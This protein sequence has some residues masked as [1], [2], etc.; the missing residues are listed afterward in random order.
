MNDPQVAD[1]ERVLVLAPQ[2]IDEALDQAL[3]ALAGAECLVCS[4]A[5]ELAR[6]VDENTGALVITDEALAGGVRPLLEALQRQPS[7][8]DVP[9]LILL[10]RAA[11]ASSARVIDLL[12]NVMILERPVRAATLV[13]AL[14]S[15]IR[16]RRRQYDLR[17]RMEALRQSEER[18]RFLA[19]N[20]PAFV[21]VAAPDGSLT[22]A[23]GKWY[24]YAGISR[25]DT[26]QWPLIVLHPED[27]DIFLQRW[28]RALAQGEDFELE[29]RCRRHD[30]VYRWFVVSAS[31]LKGADGKI[32]SWFGV[33]IDIHEQKQAERGARFLADASAALSEITDYQST[34][35]RI[36]GL[37]VPD[38][39]DWCVVDMLRDGDTLQRL[40]AMHVDPAL[41]PL[42]FELSRRYPPRRD[43]SP[44][45][46]AVD[47]RQSQTDV[48]SEE[49]LAESARDEGELEL[50]RALGM[51]SM[52]AVPL[53]C[54]GSVFGVITFVCGGTERVY[55]EHEQ[56]VAEYLA[57]RASVA[58]DNATLYRELQDAHRRKDE[59]L[60][61][62]AHELRNPLAPIRNALQVMR[63]TEDP[64]TV[65]QA[66]AIMERQLEQM[67][68]LIDDL[69]EVS[70]ITRGQ[71]SLRTERVDLATVV[72]NAV[73]TARPL[74]EGA[75][76]KLIMKLPVQPVWLEADP[77]RLAQVFSN[78]LNNAAKY[79]ERGGTIWLTAEEHD[80]RVLVSV[81]DTGIGIPAEYLS[82][83]FDIFTQVEQSPMKTQG[84]LGIGLTLVK[85]LVEMH[86]GTVEARSDGPGMGS[87]FTVTLPVATAEQPAVE[88]AMTMEA[89]AAPAGR[90]RILV[91]DDNADV[92]ESLAMM[93][94]LMGNEVRTVCDGLQAIEQTTAFAPEMVLLDIGMPGMDGYEAARRIRA[95]HWDRPLVL[96]ALTGWGQEEDRRRS[97]AA[98]FDHHFTK[99]VSPV[100]LERLVSQLPPATLPGA[101][102]QLNIEL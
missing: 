86:R 65:L 4:D 34:L 53:C 7:W 51:R 72:G 1:R 48:C 92:A 60:A 90:H 89:G 80:G 39:A 28:A 5:D 9:I 25:E 73:D 50:L 15:S 52:I 61:T 16:A 3:S 70:R 81:R 30:S 83:V 38:F 13:S 96:V 77:V 101:D 62:L 26:R 45:W 56:R 85:R 20:I 12:G 95:Q 27:R 93:L 10:D 37:A 91:A 29:V 76:H 100:N 82:R 59:F 66:R 6:R 69:L 71:F 43:L 11:L 2:P 58:I 36:A 57:R 97:L 64:D 19:D 102:V 88:V 42:A 98:G 99:P 87:A 67:V 40:A 79:T 32:I 74:I 84:G 68:R 63:L 94:R 24:E 75:G 78:L 54:R 14:R 18:F 49:T 55:T 44:V 41:V 21:W 17:S 22:Y 46:R 33:T 47:T 23:N 31:P 35:R 8:S